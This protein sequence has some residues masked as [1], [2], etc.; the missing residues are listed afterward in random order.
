MGRRAHEGMVRLS[1]E[2]VI[3]EFESLLRE[4]AEEQSH[5]HDA[6]AIHA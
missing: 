1:P 6:V 2:Q 4:L 5:E 3:R